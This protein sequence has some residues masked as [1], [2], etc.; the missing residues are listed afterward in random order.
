MIV[1]I[2][3]VE[4]AHNLAYEDLAES[5]GYPVEVLKE[6]Y[7]TEEMPQVL[8]TSFMSRYDYFF[9]K[10]SEAIE[11][12]PSLEARLKAAHDMDYFPTTYPVIVAGSPRGFSHASVVY[13]VFPGNTENNCITFHSTAMEA[14]NAAI[15]YFEKNF[16]DG[17]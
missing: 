15:V 3:I 11:E 13:K 9:D 7:A 16:K 4:M 8:L 5:I 12:Q 1:S 14:L 17:K 6:M 10:L 2:N